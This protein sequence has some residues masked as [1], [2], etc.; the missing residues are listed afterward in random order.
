MVNGTIKLSS[1]KVKL[2]GPRVVCG[3]C[4]T[5]R[6][7]TLSQNY[8]HSVLAVSLKLTLLNICEETRRVLFSDGVCTPQYISGYV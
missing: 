6:L 2:H 3:L 1:L 8:L 4:R 5:S 7:M